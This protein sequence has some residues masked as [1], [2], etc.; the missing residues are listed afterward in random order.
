[1]WPAKPDISYL[2]PCRTGS[3]GPRLA[4]CGV[5][6][7]QCLWRAA[8]FQ[9]AANHAPFCFQE[10]GPGPWHEVMPSARN[11]GGASY[12]LSHWLDLLRSLL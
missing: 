4:C 5:L 1:M 10:L 9:T 8:W 11:L 7:V 6:M 2:A 3:P 12:Q